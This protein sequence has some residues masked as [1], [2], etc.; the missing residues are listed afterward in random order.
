MRILDFFFASR[1]LLHLPIWS[2]YLVALHF[3]DELSGEGFGWTDLVVMAGISLLF[4][5]AAYLNQVFD[6]ESD[7]INNKLGFLQQG[8]ISQPQMLAAF[9]VVSLPP[10]AVAPL[11][12]MATLF[13]FAQFLLLAYLYSAPPFR[14]K[15]R[16][17][18]GL[19]ANS[20]AHGFLV[21]MAVMP[22]ISI[23][24][25]GLLGWDS[26]LYFFLTVAAVHTLTTIPD[27]E[28][29]RATG[30][31]TI[32]VVLGRGWSLAVA[33][34]FVGLSVWVAWYSGFAPLVYLSLASMFPILAAMI[35]RIDSTVLFAAKAPILALTFMAG[36]FFPLYF[37]FV[38][39]LL[40]G[41]RIYYLKRFNMIYPKLA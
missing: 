2:V 23:H 31:T 19:F 20:W 5:G 4:S 16:P 35:I 40:F 41:C 21:A 18:L 29:D 3:H 13:I 33:L 8:F 32:G 24:N 14:L 37:V 30:K 27:R 9:V 11:F 7:R 17:I 1:P 36:Y 12:S 25:A 15:D 39:A 38:V 26:P 6:F 28:G 22:D 10:M 34:V